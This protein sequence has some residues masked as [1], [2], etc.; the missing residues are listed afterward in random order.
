MLASILLLSPATMAPAISASNDAAAAVV[1]G[2]ADAAKKFAAATANA[3]ATTTAATTAAV[4]AVVRACAAAATACGAALAAL[5]ARCQLAL[6]CLFGGPAPQD[7][8]PCTCTCPTVPTVHMVP[9][10]PTP[11]ATADAAVTAATTATVT[12]TD[13]VKAVAV[14]SD[15]SALVGTSKDGVAAAMDSTDGAALA[16]G[17]ASE[18]EE[19]VEPAQELALPR[20]LAEHEPSIDDP[21]TW[22]AAEAL[23]AR[24][25]ALG[26]VPRDTVLRLVSCLHAQNNG[27]PF[28]LAYPLAIVDVALRALACHAFDVA[29]VHT[30]LSG[31]WMRYYRIDRLLRKRYM[32]KGNLVGLDELSELRRETL[33]NAYAP[34]SW[35]CPVATK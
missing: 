7:T 14:P 16:T 1:A 19:E 23:T 5:W 6:Q 24:H 20:E 18:P 15:P 30:E 34:G 32:R 31:R 8:A 13:E 27:R 4:K 21:L 3:T 29:A 26:H 17:I 35:W 9:P 2:A 28:V 33:T 22:A 12:I 11:E 10:V 25:E